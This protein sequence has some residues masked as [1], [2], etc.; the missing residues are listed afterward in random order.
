MAGTDSYTK[1]KRQVVGWVAT[2]LGAAAIAGVGWST[3][4]LYGHDSDI[5]TLQVRQDIHEK[6]AEEDR[7][8]MKAMQRQILEELRSR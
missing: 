5:K 7:S 4:K 6:R 1:D 3:G 2:S 8:E